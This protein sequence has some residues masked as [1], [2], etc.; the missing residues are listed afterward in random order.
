MGAFSGQYPRELGKVIAHAKRLTKVLTKIERSGADPWFLGRAGELRG[1][2]SLALADW[3]SGASD[4][5]AAGKAIASYIDALHQG[6]SMRLRCGLALECCETGDVITAVAPDEERSMAG[7]DTASTVATQATNAPTVQTGW[8]DSSE[9]LA[10]VRDGLGLVQMNARMIARRVGHGCATMDDLLAFGR[11]GLLD[12]ARAF[13]ERRGVPFDQWASLRIRN[14]M[15]DGVRRWG[16]IPARA[17]ARL[18]GLEAADSAKSANDNQD[19]ANGDG[20]SESS[21]LLAARP[22]D[23]PVGTGEGD[24]MNGLGVTPEDLLAKAQLASL[25]REI[26]AKLPNRERALIERS[27]F[28]G[29]TIDQAAASMGVSR[30]WASRVH[31]RAIEMMERQLRKRDRIPVAGGGRAWG[32]K[33]S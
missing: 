16:A 13:D 3:R 28:N 17:R 27:Y 2:V 33:R 7:T 26:V 25:V 14:A 29:Q 15:I 24:G 21:A 31:A 30:S 23:M 10:R 6:A 5:E 1:V 22:G 8:V 19:Q 4:T 12:A 11:E 32:P 9:M 18:R 20:T